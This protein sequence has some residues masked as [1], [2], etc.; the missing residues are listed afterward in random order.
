ML[1]IQTVGPESLQSGP[2]SIWAR[3]PCRGGLLPMMNDQ[4][5]GCQGER[6]RSYSVLG[7]PELQWEDQRLGEGYPQTTP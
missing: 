3:G 6:L 7:A 2:N 4:W 5:P 1:Q